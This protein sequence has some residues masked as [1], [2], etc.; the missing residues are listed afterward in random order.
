MALL[1]YKKI[2]DHKKK[3]KTKELSNWR[4]F[5]DDKYENKWLY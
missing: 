5:S 3:E 4:A 1:T 2:D